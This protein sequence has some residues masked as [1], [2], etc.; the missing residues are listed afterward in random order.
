MGETS[1]KIRFDI[2]NCEKGFVKPSV[3]QIQKSLSLVPLNKEH[4]IDLNIEV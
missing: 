3:W 1:A 4:D 2:F